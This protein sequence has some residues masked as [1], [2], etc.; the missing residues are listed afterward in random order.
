MRETTW[1]IRGLPFA[2]L[3]WGEGAPVVLLHGFLDSAAA[4]EHIAG[5]LDGWRIAMDLRGHGRSPHVGPGE[6]YFFPDYLADLDGLIDQLPGPVDLVGHS[7]GGTVVTMYAGAR[8]E[9]VR[10]IVSIDGLGLPDSSGSA[11]ERMQRFMSGANRPPRNKVFANVEEAALRLRQAHPALDEAW[12]LRLAGRTTMPVDG[13]VSWS[14]DPRHRIRGP[15]P[16]RHDNHLQFLR[17]IRCPVLSVHPQRSPFAGEDV[18][19]LEEVIQDL[20]VVEIPGAGHMVHLDAPEAVAEAVAAF[21]RLD[22]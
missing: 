8:P 11:I 2:A 19:T 7:L 9:K 3:E 20:Q 6:A 22:N 16:Y 5:R 10:R 4:W 17:A 14:W 15:I 21:L 12:S 1:H 13:G 18:R